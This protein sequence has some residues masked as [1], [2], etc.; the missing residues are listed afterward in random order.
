M[1]KKAVKKI[2][3]KESNDPEQDLAYW[4]GKSPEDRVSAV[5]DLRRQVYGNIARLERTVRIIH[6][7]TYL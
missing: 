6:R 2:G 5:E 4:L 7:A 3:L 1:I